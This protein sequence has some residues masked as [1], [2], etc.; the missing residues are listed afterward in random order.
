MFVENLGQ[1]DNLD[2]ADNAPNARFVVQGNRGVL[3]IDESGIWLT[4]LEP[5]PSSGVAPDEKEPE[6]M[7]T[8]APGWGVSDD[9]GKPRRGVNIRISFVGANSDPSMDGVNP[10]DTTVSYFIGADPKSWH[11][12][13]P[14]W[15][16]VRYLD[17]YPE[18]DLVL[19][20]D[21][22]AWAWELTLKEQKPTALQ[23][24]GAPLQLSTPVESIRFKV[25]GAQGMALDQDLI[26]I[27]TE[28][29]EIPLPL[30][31]VIKVD[32][33]RI[34]PADLAAELDGD[35]IVISLATA[36]AGAGPTPTESV[37]STAT[38][39]V[40]ATLEPTGTDTQ[41]PEE[42]ASQEPM[43][44][45]VTP[46]DT[47]APEP[48]ATTTLEP[49]G[50]PT[51]EATPQE[52]P[53]PSPSPTEESAILEGSPVLGALGLAVPAVQVA[54]EMPRLDHRVSVPA[55][56]GVEDLIFATLFG[57]TGFGHAIGVDANGA[58]YITGST[59]SATFPTTPGGFQQLSAGNAE[60]FIS[61]M[62]AGGTAL[63]YSTYLG[64]SGDESGR[65]ITV[66][67]SGYAYVT[68]YSTSSDFPTT[69]GAY[70]TQYD[71]LQDP[72][73]T[74]LNAD[75]TAL[76]YST[77]IGTGQGFDVVVDGAGSAYVVGQSESSTFP[78]TSGAYDTTHN[79]GFD[80]FISK[81]DPAGSDL[82][83]STYFGGSGADCEISGNLR[84]C[85]IDIDV[86]RAAYVAGSTLS[87]NFP[88]TE[89][90]YDRTR[91]GSYS[92]DG[93][94]LK[95]NPSG[96]GLVYSTYLGSTGTECR[97]TCAIEVDLSG[98][99]YIVGDTSNSGFP[100]TPGA[101]D[102][103]FNG[104][105]DVF[106]TKLTASGNDL[107]FS[108]FLG[109]YYYDYGLDVAVSE[110]GMSYLTGITYSSDF[111]VTQDAYQ[112]IFAGGEKDA[113]LAM[114]TPDGQGVVYSTYLGGSGWDEGLGVAIY[115]SGPAYVTGW[116]S[117][118]DFPT[119]PGAFAEELIG[120]DSPFIAKLAGAFES[121]VADLAVRSSCKPESGFSEAR[122]CPW[123]GPAQAQGEAGDPINTRTGGL[124][125]PVED[126]SLPT[127]GGALSF[128]R[129]YSS[130]A[131]QGDPASLGYGWTHNHDTRL[132]FPGDPGGQ[133]GIVLFKAHSANQYAFIDNG[134]G[135]YSPSTGVPGILTQDPGP[136]VT[137]TVVDSSQR[138]YHF[139]DI[140]RIV[141]WED[142]QGHTWTYAYDGDGRLD[143]VTADTGQRFIDLTY[144]P[145]G[146]IER[147]ADHTGRDVEFGYD[148]AGDLTTHIDVLSQTWTYEYDTSHRLRKVIDPAGREV[149]HTEYDAQGRAFQQYDANNNLVVEI[150]YN[151]DGTSVVEDA[152]G[153]QTTH[154]YDQRN[155]LTGRTDPLANGSSRE[156]DFNFRPSQITDE[157]ANVTQLTWS[158]DGANLEAII[159]GEL[160]T[161]DLGY[162][163][164]NNLTQV[165]DGRGNVTIYEYNETDPDPDRRT[166]L[167][168]VDG[169][170]P[171]T[172]DTTTYTYTT[173]ADA[174]QPHG[175]LKTITD[176][177]SNVTQFVYDQFGQ[178][179]EVIDP[180]LNSI[181]YTYDSPGRLKT[182][183]DPLGHV[184]W[185]CFDAAGRMV[186]S[187]ANATGDGGTPQTDPCNA[188]SYLPG[189]DPAFDR[190]TI[191]DY[192]NAGDLI[193]TIDSS[194]V[195]TRT[196]YDTSSRPQ[197]VV[198]NLV[199]QGIEVATPPVYNPAFPDRNVRTETVYDGQG[200]AIATIDNAGVITRTYYDPLNRPKYVVINLV[201]QAISV[202]SPPA[203]N[204][205]N[206]DQNVRTETV[207][208]GAGNP[209][210]TINTLG[211][212]TRTYYDGNNRPETIVQ[213]L[214]GQPISNTTPPARDPAFP[215]RNLRT[216]TTYDQ[217]SNAIA[218]TDPLGII[219]RSY[220]DPL[221]RPEYVVQNLI[222]QGISVGTPPAFDPAFPDRNVRTQFVY[223]NT[224]NQ[225]A[226][227]DTNGVITRT[228]YDDANRPTDV[229]RNLVGQG[230]GV[231]TPPAYNPA[232]PDQNV[233]TQT[234]YDDAGRSIAEIDNAGVITRTYYDGLGRV[235]YVV[236]NLTGQAITVETP[237]A[238]NPA[239]PDQNVRTETVYD[240]N[241]DAIASIDP[242]GVISRNYYDDLHRAVTAVQNLTGQSISV[243]TPPAFNPAFPDQ[244]VRTDTVY[245][246]AGQVARTT[247]TLG[248][249]TVSCHDGQYRVV[250]SIQNPT[251][252]T[253]CSSYTPTSQ[254]DE[255][256]ITLTVYDGAGNWLSLTD[257]NGKQTSFG[258]DEIYRLD[259]QTDPMGHPTTFGYDLD[260]NRVSMTDAELVV[261]RYEYDALARLTA[262]V[263][264]YVQGMPTNQE[265][266]VRTEYACDGVGN[267]LSILDGN[268]HSTTF[269]Y[270]ALGRLKTESDALSHT[271]TYSY[272]AAGD[273]ASL[274]D[275]NG[276][277][278][279]FGY[280][281]L[282]RLTAIDYPA[283]DVDVSFVYDAAGNRL[284][285][286]DGVGSTQWVYDDLNRTTSIT[287]PFGG[288]VGYG[289]DGLGNRTSLDYPGALPAIA[290]VYDDASR[291]QTVTDWDSL[292]TTY[293]FDKGGRLGTVT[294]P[295]GIVSTYSYNDASQLLSLTHIKDST[296]FASY[297]YTYDDVGNRLTAAES[298]RVPQA[299]S[300]R[301]WVGDTGSNR[302]LLFDIATVTNG[303]N[304]IDLLGETDAAGAPLYSK[305]GPNDGPNARGFNAL[306]DSVIDPTIHRLFVSDTTNNRVLVFDLDSSN[307][308][309]D[310]VA[311]AVLGQPNLTS[312]AAALTASGMNA[313]RGL[314]LQGTANRLFV[315]DTGY[316][317][318][319]VFDVAA[320]SNGEAAINVL[321]QTSFTA[322]GTGL[323]QNR[324]NGP[325]ALAFSGDLLFVADSSNN[326]VLVFNVLA[327]S[328]GENAVNVLG[329][330]SYTT[331]TAATSQTGLRS[332]RGVAVGGSNRLFVADTTNNRV[333]VFNISTITNGEAAVNV[334]GQS[335]YT[336][337]TAATSSTGLR[338]PEDV[339]AEASTRL[340]VGD[341]NN[342]R[343]M[344]FDIVSISNGE[345]AVNVLG[346]TTFTA[347]SA[348]TT[349]A[350]LSS[351]TG[352]YLQSSLLYAADGGNNRLMV[353]DVASIANGEDAVHLAGQVDGSLSPVYTKGAVNDG[354][355]AQGFA[356]SGAVSD[357]AVDP[358]GHR[359]FA[360]DPTNNRVL[361]FDLDPDNVLL[362]RLPDAV[363]GQS[364][365]YA[366][367]AATT[368]SQFSSPRGLTFD[369]VGNRL[370]VAD[371]TNHR[372]MVFDVAA[373]ANGENAV[374]VL[375]QA[376]FTTSTGAT[377]QTG[378]KNPVGLSLD[379]AR[380]WLF[381]ADYSN[382]RVMVFDVNTI[383][384]GEAAINVLGQASFTTSTAA[385][386][387]SGLRNPSGAAFESGTSRLFV[388]D[389]NNHRV[390]VFDA[391]AL[392]NGE[393]AINVL[394]QT[395]FTAGTGATSQS[396]MKNPQGA[397]IDPLTHA[398]FVADTN[399]HRVTVYDVTA[400]TNGENATGVLGQAN[401]TSGSAATAQNR[402][403]SPRGVTLL[404]QPVVTATIAYDYDPLYRLTAA[405]Y[406][407]G[408]LFHYTYDAVGNRQTEET[409]AGETTYEYDIAN[410]L[411][412][413]DGET[414]TWSNNGNLL[415][416]G[417]STYTYTH[418]NRL[419]SVVHDAI[420]YTFAY[421]GLGDRL[422]QT[423]NGSPTN[424]ALDLAAGLTQVL[425]DGTNAYLYGVA[426][427][428]EEQPGG[429]QY[430][431]GDAL[432]SVRQLA[433]AGATVTL[434][435]SFE[436]FGDTLTSTGAGGTAFQFTGEQRD[437]TGLTYLRARYYASYL[438][439][440]IQPDPIVP[441][442]YIPADWNR[443]AYVR[444]N[445]INL[446]DPFGLDPNCQ[447]DARTCAIERA[448]VGILGN[449]HGLAGLQALFADRELY[450]VWGAVAGRTIGTRLDWILEISRSVWTTVSL[451][452]PFDGC[453]FDIPDLY[454]NRLGNNPYGYGRGFGFLDATDFRAEFVEP[455]RS[456]QA[457]HFLTA[458]AL[459]E[460]SDLLPWAEFGL[461][462][463][464]GHEKYATPPGQ[465]DPS[466]YARLRQFL[467]VTQ[468]DRGR[469]RQA[470]EYDARGMR[471]ERDEELWPILEFDAGIP[472]GGIDP[473]RP[474]NTLQD[475][476]LSVKGYRFA[477]WVQSRSGDA[478]WTAVDWLYRELA[479][480]GAWQPM[481]WW[482]DRPSGR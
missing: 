459:S 330:S 435:R 359:L 285:M 37:T 327:I 245:G 224:G 461:T 32:G 50:E 254:P 216:D 183:E 443:Y 363:L 62:N 67:P 65:G 288:A 53:A 355:N 109:G 144:D 432:G 199:G 313:P 197:F 210:A 284:N 414:Y 13:V 121:V 160:N 350:R 81:L 38:E 123:T 371:Y 200:N 66:D 232:F 108:T 450:E 431:L 129:T 16:G 11:P 163:A 46:A 366:G 87:S 361:V 339:I 378:L 377:T 139:S 111:W 340:F 179:I 259:T 25:E 385:T 104:G 44:D 306:Y 394:G 446:T 10:L 17:L 255:D 475:L 467:S 75:G 72:F 326:R 105:Y 387:Q 82:L 325:R 100:T 294:V 404:A 315:A 474:G 282:N 124:D 176:P 442:P 21:H 460:Y 384:N 172:S 328:N 127:S 373:I 248:H 430:H 308:L 219:T 89:G 341:T 412:S 42:T 343:I 307:L 427:I 24:E 336:T 57:A 173:A 480:P 59:L 286:T 185:T 368:Q 9:E 148:P 178:R 353:F 263:E 311:D 292:L 186:R 222:G 94:V 76:V 56:D 242:N 74:K 279:V 417:A 421:N 188:A 251:T 345:A 168:S 198:Q 376:T 348:A 181:L 389:T 334:L 78:V 381:V 202:G 416:D 252:G 309:V 241:D 481:R 329:Q 206:P 142:A 146:R 407:N 92:T 398:L 447:D 237:A 271:T 352:V 2:G 119:T 299:A 337:S 482:N 7:P 131:A 331:N 128:Q 122:E 428:G 244:N 424:Y 420:T 264:N 71:T 3:R 166:L 477:R 229:V 291:L 423:I 159:D 305:N 386:T 23:G 356:L 419:A 31:A 234:L 466:G 158:A 8:P 321:G 12:D 126:I 86:D 476:R 372:V 402:M 201:G 426:R 132:I 61:K 437:G 298:L 347:G 114:F 300:T 270:D 283:P 189:A 418:A 409:Q 310:R 247:D 471:R 211:M 221:N 112:P 64:G 433:N 164:L 375:G 231:S 130:I 357:L 192:D 240:A 135:S 218:T 415:G 182:V 212:I 401:F 445:P 320:I 322:G 383:A 465:Q 153:N 151:L 301:L 365:L 14:I 268:S 382:H 479:A 141:S 162:D 40:T 106:L 239:F 228:Y 115:R 425:S 290:Y 22:G 55:F 70:D 400:I 156:Y 273:R 246:D 392:T 312:G 380:G 63:I 280:D 411:T 80:G 388:A 403:S 399:N 18:V 454:W 39:T 441:D 349:Q 351:P 393:N 28:F 149:V 36:E 332:P 137:Y 88:T 227:I 184:N 26:R 453:T 220:Y 374:N 317:R 324:L 147:V 333:M 30:P 304:A 83:Y 191:S 478:P 95:L 367:S 134:D 6:I 316:N 208:D 69:Q 47:P 85:S 79:G 217:N 281:D 379:S 406:D 177:D 152:I 15:E 99:A 93:F 143:T 276:F 362:D 233:R 171:G 318:V 275:A 58:T 346:Q 253:P 261:T 190:I 150:T 97:Y 140:G 463:I 354:P 260:G 225:I 296:T 138:T 473:L 369:P 27:T 167:Q 440:W 20:S 323:A 98:A 45:T 125:L 29:G 444:N 154:A 214:V 448:V 136:P 77:F 410:R 391:A 274:L 319:L 297:V 34:A 195:I 155:T 96:S 238:H 54:Y 464:I 120:A 84:E 169:A 117:S 43:V 48:S 157:N 293:T 289:Y 287:D 207:Y 161:I 110:G 314:A 468:A 455:D 203:F 452:K 243:T 103:T 257:P 52:S 180:L 230:I 272:D 267:R 458:V 193:A 5:L 396:R 133:P 408:T 405:D 102:T 226:V 470:V 395:S 101:F 68:G 397:S 194:G 213:N 269:M 116:T 223:D 422:R 145:Q 73:V 256:L 60:A 235:R 451:P 113:F 413:V 170:L 33:S 358:I 364:S 370:F 205:T 456:D 303:E 360:S 390:M 118:S 1:F 204:P 41:V 236:R 266:N 19:T 90:A 457:S 262:V 107:H 278:T 174:P 439:Q 434:G 265:R 258:Y 472:F 344:V 438:N 469:F 277:M 91:N 4:V 209:I 338:A 196:Y 342:H 51:T 302:E 35:E 335:S 249:A 295:N 436:P 449:N 429:W 462:A 250:K 215:D 49:T 175:L 165:T 187:V